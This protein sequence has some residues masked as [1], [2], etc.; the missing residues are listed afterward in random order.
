MQI[1][2]TVAWNGSAAS[3]KA[4]LWAIERERSHGGGILL[5]AIIDA[6][7]RPFGHTA[8]AELTATAE[9]AIEAEAAWVHSAHPGISLESQLVVADRQRALLDECPSGSMLVLGVEERAAKVKRW[10]LT[11]RVAATA[12]V[13]VVVVPSTP[14]A[15]RFGVVVGADGSENAFAAVRVAA[16]EARHRGEPLHIVRAWPSTGPMSEQIE[17]AF[18]DDAAEQHRLVNEW[19]EQVRADVPSIEVHGHVD[20]GPPAAALTRRA[21]TAALLVVGSRGHGQARQ[22]LL[23]SV[24]RTLVLGASRCPVVVVPT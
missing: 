16:D 19:V 12:S 13:P 24:S 11:A 10:S 2:S 1:T 23:G 15:D 3:R 20:P 18:A 17:G 5:L 6:R 9:R 4:L 22:F 21:L 8:I 7:L 14:V